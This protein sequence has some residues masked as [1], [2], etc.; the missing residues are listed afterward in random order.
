MIINT[1]QRTDIPAFYS[2]WFVNRIKEGFVYVRNP[3]FPNKVTKYILDSK[4]VDVI[5]FCTKNPEP[6]FKYLDE[7]KEYKMLWYIT[8]TAFSHDLEPNVCHVDKAIESFKFL[9]SKLG[10]NCVSL[11]YTPIIVN[12]RYPVERHIKAFEYILSNLSGYTNLCAFGFVDLYDKIK[13]NHPEIKDC[14]DED[15]IRITL[16]FKKIAAKYNIKLRLCSKEK[17][18]SKYGI[19]VQGCMRLEDYEAAA[20]NSLYPKNIMQARKGY[21]ACMLANDIGAYNCCMH[22]CKYCYANSNPQ[23]VYNNYKL[24]DDNSPLLI[25]NINSNDVI[26]EVVGESWIVKNEGIFK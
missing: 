8:I 19:D 6:M 1:G 26:T 14:S 17:W 15:K 16:E 20:C 12:D 23:S 3:Y 21:C 24:H 4:V 11:R 22:L 13:K 5:G 9:S 10:K 2:K 25:G 7:L 18:L